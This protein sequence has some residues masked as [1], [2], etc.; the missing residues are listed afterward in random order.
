MGFPGELAVDRGDGGFGWEETGVGLVLVGLGG[1]QAW[2][3]KLVRCLDPGLGT[4]V[5]GRGRFWV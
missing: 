4:G 3:V 1:V 5:D 2:A